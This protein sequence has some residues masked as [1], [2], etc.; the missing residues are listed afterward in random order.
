MAVTKQ[1][2]TQLLLSGTD[3]RTI[4]SEKGLSNYGIAFDDDNLINRGS[5]TCNLITDNHIEYLQNKISGN[6]TNADWAHLVNE[7]QDG[8]KMEI[9]GTTDTN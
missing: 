8:I 6:E 2:I 1:K 5:C 7:V 3:E 4:S 9:S